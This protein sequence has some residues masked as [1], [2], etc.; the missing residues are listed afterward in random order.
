MDVGDNNA[1]SMDAF[2]LSAIDE[3]KIIDFSYTST[4]YILG[5]PRSMLFL[6]QSL[7]IFAEDCFLIPHLQVFFSATLA[8]F[9]GILEMLSLFPPNILGTFICTYN[10]HMLEHTQVAQFF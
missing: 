3:M 7:P 8:A 10:L 4:M 9:I 2:F 6:L 1:F 5:T